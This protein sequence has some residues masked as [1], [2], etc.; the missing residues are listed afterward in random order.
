MNAQ[1]SAPLE[2][3]LEVS[4]G[5]LVC[6]GVLE[7]LIGGLLGLLSIGT[8]FLV[9]F[10]EGILRASMP[11]GGARA[12]IFPILLYGAAALVFLFAGAGTLG[13][14]R[15]ARTM[16]LVLS[17]F[18]LA[19]GILGGAA[20]LL[21]V[22][23]ILGQAGGSQAVSPG[24]RFFVW[25]LLGGMILLFSIGLPSSFLVF[26]TRKSVKAA[27]EKREPTEASQGKLP[28]PVAILA[29]WIGF[30]AL[31]SLCSV[32]YGFLALFG[33]LI[34]GAPAM[35]LSLM[36]ACFQGFLAWRLVRRE[37][38]VWWAAFL[39]YLL[40]GIS[41]FVT[42]SR[43]PMSELFAALGSGQA[44]DPTQRQV[45]LALQSYLPWLALVGQVLFLGLIL[46]AKRYFRPRVEIA[47]P[48]AV[49]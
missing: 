21:V 46:Y 24:V 14:R 2:R 27:F 41:G 10:G 36:G 11:V 5:W 6:F 48:L 18:W 17:W 49:S 29:V 15:W 22:P 37:E 38:K 42:F 23:F 45:M 3:A 19:C 20:V 33:F 40:M 30:G 34:H 43:I 7:L 1:E 13:R 8:M 47:E 4:R 25:I 28:F 44:A 26:Y 32:S 16:M 31:A 12:L 35:L 39:Y 9:L